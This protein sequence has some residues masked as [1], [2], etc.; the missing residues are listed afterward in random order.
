VSYVSLL[1]V[2]GGYSYYSHG[3]S[4]ISEKRILLIVEIESSQ[5]Q[6]RHSMSRVVKTGHCTKYL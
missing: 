4:K 5:L 6:L 3:E 2:S 1:K